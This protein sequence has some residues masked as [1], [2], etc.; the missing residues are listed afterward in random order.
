MLTIIPFI[1][2]AVCAL[3]PLLV[4]AC[5]SSHRHALAS[6]SN[7]APEQRKTV[8][9]TTQREGDVTQF[10][11]E[12]TE[13]C[14]VTV[15]FE[16]AATNL[17]SSVKLPYTA[18][19]PARTI[20]QAFTMQPDSAAKPWQY[21][22]NSHYKL[23][24]HIARHDDSYVYL[25]PYQPGREFTVTQAY[26]GNYSHKGANKYAIDWKMP[27]GTTVLAARPGMVVKIRAE[28]DIGGPS[29][30]FDRDNNYVLIR[31]D[32][33]TLAHYCH[34]QKSGNLVNVGDFVSAGQPIARS[35]NTGFSS[36]PHLHFCVFK[37]IS[38]RERAS[39]PI[40]FQTAEARAVTLKAHK[41]YT[42]PE[43]RG[44]TTVAAGMAS[45]AQ[46]LRS[47]GAAGE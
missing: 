25:L 33:G 29:I 34:L 2:C 44:I 27:E 31:H 9:I 35:G 42:A 47:Q 24:S 5:T 39:V 16:F 32:D 18:T 23:G 19:Y 26:D 4:G 30:E 46:G 8:R 45:S 28:S 41:R 37:T 14:E 11:V 6:G 13:F 43:L 17:S 12:N 20:S 7:P 3:L 21:S 15:T 22:Y 40:R 38:G 36:G 10:L 1:R